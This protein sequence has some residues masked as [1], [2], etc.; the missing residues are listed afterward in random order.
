MDEAKHDGGERL[1]W[2]W[3]LSVLI[4]RM[5]VS[6][7]NRSRWHSILFLPHGV[8]CLG[9]EARSSLAYCRLFR[10]APPTAIRGNF[11]LL[12]PAS[13]SSSPLTCVEEGTRA[14]QRAA[15]APPSRETKKNHSLSEK[16]G[17]RR[18]LNATHVSVV[19]GESIE[20]RQGN[21]FAFPDGEKILERLH[22]RPTP[23][24]E[25][26]RKATTESYISPLHTTG[27]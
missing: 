17:D 1:T 21:I 12:F 15:C 5:H 8:Q 26:G 6:R 4:L 16:T 3:R 23:A 2:V 13:S 19:S 14:W 25:A 27:I 20:Q 22:F 9:S 10:L 7:V 11:F 18:Q 24:V